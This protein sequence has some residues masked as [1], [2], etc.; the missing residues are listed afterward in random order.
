MLKNITDLNL[1]KVVYILKLAIQEPM[2]PGKDLH[3]RVYKAEELGFEGIEFWGRGI[4]D[5]VDEILSAISTSRVK[6]STICAGYRG[7]LLSADRS[8]RELAMREI[9]SKLSAASRLEAVGLIVVPIFGKAVLPDLYPLY[10]TIEE[11]E[12]RLLVEELKDLGKYAEEVGSYILLEPLNRYETHFINRL[13][14]AVEICEE[15]KMEYIKIMADVFHMNIEEADIPKSIKEAGEYI[16]HV[17]LADSNRYVPGYG[18]TDFKS[19]FDAL[20]DIKYGYY[21]ALECRVPEPREETLKRTVEF[22][23][24][25][26]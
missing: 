6:V 16:R 15:L 22:L 13:E 19:I 2:L 25:L 26:M 8:E 11:L 1:L 7:N 20:K 24:R 12:R 17:H 21:M 10:S 14:Q 23:R 4:E 5:R 3:E 9:K 18:H